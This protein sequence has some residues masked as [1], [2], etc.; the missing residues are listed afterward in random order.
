MVTVSRL[1][2]SSPIDRPLPNQGRGRADA[3]AHETRVLARVLK[4]RNY[5]FPSVFECLRVLSLAISAP[6]II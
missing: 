5:V 6:E 2:E 4:L 3:E 1:V